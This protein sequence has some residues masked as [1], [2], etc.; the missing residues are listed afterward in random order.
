MGKKINK[1]V[2]YVGAIVFAVLLFFVSYVV[3]TAEVFGVSA[4]EGVVL[5]DLLDF[6][7]AHATFAFIFA[8]VTAVATIGAVAV[9]VLDDL[10]IISAGKIAKLIGL[11][12]VIAGVACLV[13]S[14]IMI[15]DFNSDAVLSLIATY[16]IGF[17]PVSAVLAG[18][19]AI[20][21]AVLFGEE[22][23]GKKK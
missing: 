8:L 16:S 10:G 15:I 19:C 22:K 3:V 6:E 21:P 5:G 20:L 4:S 23:K 17:A 11:V 2:L 18:V 13:A 1:Y 7:M 12:A 14:F 9:G